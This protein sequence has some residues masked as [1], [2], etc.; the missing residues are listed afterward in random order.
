VL[1]IP[2]QPIL[3]DSFIE[4]ARACLKRMTK[5]NVRN[6]ALKFKKV[7]AI[8]MLNSSEEARGVWGQLR[9]KWRAYGDKHPEEMQEV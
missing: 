4:E 9:E 5:A 2:G 3:A 1:P 6:L 8:D 7:T